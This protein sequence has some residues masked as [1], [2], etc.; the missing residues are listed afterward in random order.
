MVFDFG[1][2]TGERM[3]RGNTVKTRIGIACA[4]LV[5]GLGLSACSNSLTYAPTPANCLLEEQSG[6][7]FRERHTGLL[8]NTA[9]SAKPWR[10][11]S[12]ND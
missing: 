7:G 8:V 6:G 10:S 4:I 3:M 11:L 5:A 1:Q 9:I 12:A 2:E